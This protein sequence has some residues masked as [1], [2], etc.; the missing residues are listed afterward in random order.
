MSRKRRLSVSLDE[1]AYARLRL[2]ALQQSWNPGAGTTG[3]VT[4]GAVLAA[5][6]RAHLPDY[7][8]VDQQRWLAH[9]SKSAPAHASKSAHSQRSIRDGQAQSQ[10]ARGRARPR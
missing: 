10:P 5:L 1:D 9:A 2:H 6:V 4:A 7:E 3:A 8:V